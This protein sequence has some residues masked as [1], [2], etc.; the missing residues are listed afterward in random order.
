MHYSRWRTEGDPLVSKYNR[1]SVG[2]AP[3][4]VSQR[5][6]LAKVDQS[7]GPDS[8]WPWLGSFFAS[9]HGRFKPNGA[10]Y[11][12]GAHRFAYTLF[13]GPIPEDRPEI[14]HLC[15]TRDGS[16]E[17]GTGCLHRRCVNPSH[18]EPVTSGENFRRGRNHVVPRLRWVL[19]PAS[20]EVCYQGH[21]YT[22]Q[23]IYVEPSGKRRCRLCR[24]EA[25]RR[26]RESA[27]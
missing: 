2:V 27:A 23:T 17:G 6:F 9:G 20:E 3:E 21:R 26:R 13:V 16:C 18:L 15:H 19:N 22:E 8:C 5:A 1:A 12:N 11:S 25:D 14:D 7:G 24:R 4:E 10:Q